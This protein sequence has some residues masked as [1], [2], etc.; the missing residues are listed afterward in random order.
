MRAYNFGS[1]W[2]NLTKFLPGDVAHSRGD[3]VVTNF[4]R[5]AP[6]KIWEGKK[7]QKFSAICNN[8]RL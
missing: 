8:F 1:S 4:A 6:Y 7:R 3:N 5:G 2:H